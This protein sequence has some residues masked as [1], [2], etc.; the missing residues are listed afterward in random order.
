MA[1]H[2]FGGLVKLRCRVSVTSHVVWLVF[3][4]SRQD[5]EFFLEGGQRHPGFEF[6]PSSV[7]GPPSPGLIPFS[8]NSSPFAREELSA[9]SACDHPGCGGIF[10]PPGGFCAAQQEGVRTTLSRHEALPWVGALKI[11]DAPLHP[12]QKGLG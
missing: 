4:V 1:L 2:L 11:R 10:G 7:S 12:W 9:L 3:L 6:S 5:R 8:V